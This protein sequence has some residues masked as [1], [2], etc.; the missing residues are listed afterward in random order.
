MA[1]G[2]TADPEASF[3]RDTEERKGEKGWK[4]KTMTHLLLMLLEAAEAARDDERN[5]FVV[6][7]DEDDRND[8]MKPIIDTDSEYYSDARLI[9]RDVE[10]ILS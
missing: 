2:A 4:H 1:D 5:P 7:D 6:A 10:A 9:E 8:S 3:D